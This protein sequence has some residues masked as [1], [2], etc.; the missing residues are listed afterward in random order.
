MGGR[1]REYPSL[2]GVPPP[3]HGP[4]H[5]CLLV[6]GH[7]VGLVANL[8][9]DNLDRWADTSC[10]RPFVDAGLLDFA[11]LDAGSSEEL[12]LRQSKVSWGGCYWSRSCH[13]WTR[14]RWVLPCLSLH[15]PNALAVDS[16][17]LCM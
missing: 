4:W 10:L 8:S 2:L 15:C 12:H 11:I 9:A 1:L 16:W 13:W 6:A 3:P 5:A 14:R 7:W 17:L